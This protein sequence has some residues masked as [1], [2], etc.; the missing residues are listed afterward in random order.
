MFI[1]PDLKFQ[2]CGND[3]IS[4]GKKGNKWN[5]QIFIPMVFLLVRSTAMA[6]RAAAVSRIAAIRFIP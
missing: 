4:H 2:S 6:A 5:R 1:S 3:Q